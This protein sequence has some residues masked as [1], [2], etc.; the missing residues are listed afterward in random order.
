MIFSGWVLQQND[1]LNHLRYRRERGSSGIETNS[2]N[3]D[4]LE[5]NHHS[6]FLISL[7]YEVHWSDKICNTAWSITFIFL[8]SFVLCKLHV[9]ILYTTKQYS[10]CFTSI[11]FQTGGISI[12]PRYTSD[13]MYTM[14][15]LPTYTIFEGCGRSTKSKSP[16]QEITI[17]ESFW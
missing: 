14:N 12:H 3:G 7:I 1:L 17:S 4:R 13:L 5:Y 15:S 11:Y 6:I 8:Y 16:R 10:C 9:S 2:T